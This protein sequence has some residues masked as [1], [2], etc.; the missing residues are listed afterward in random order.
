MFVDVDDLLLAAGFLR[1]LRK[2]VL[3]NT[4]DFGVPAE[5]VDQSTHPLPTPAQTHT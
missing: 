2:H 4:L 1:T 3:P 5:T